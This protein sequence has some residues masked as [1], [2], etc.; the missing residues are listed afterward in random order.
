MM[1]F[2]FRKVDMEKSKVS[3]DESG[4][5]RRN[6]VENSSQRVDNLLL[7]VG[8][9]PLVRFNRITENLKTTI[10][11]KPEFMNPGGSVKDRMVVYILASALTG[12]KIGPNTAIIEAT[13]GNTGVAVAMFGAVHNR[14]VILT[15]PDKMSDE[16]INTL[17]AYGAEVHICPAAVPA[18]SPESYYNVAL[19]RAKEVGDYFMLNQY[20][21]LE[22]PE[23]H[24][25]TTG[26]EIWRQV[27]G[28]IDIL[29]GGVGTGGT[30]SG[31]SRYLKEQNP[32][33]ISVA[34]DPI[35]SVF[36]D[37]GTTGKLIEPHPYFVEGIGEDKPC[38]TMQYE[39][40][41]HFIKVS[42]KE[43]FLA[44]RELTVKEG[45]LVGGSSGSAVHGALK[46]AREHDKDQVMVV[47]LPDSGVKYLSRIYNDD[48]MR[49]HDFLD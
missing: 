31:T 46:F 20:E 17:R 43:S 45:I 32:E 5:R 10:Y 14:R 2:G 41:D 47:I 19:T 13:S 8:N 6:I 36:A 44:A 18:D 4:M 30:M 16:K 21:N 1:Y 12:G 38:P 34:I 24:Y 15:I 29:V 35:G 22:N 49:E 25:L 7:A 37:H 3:A 33:L 26:P 40:I 42:D 27:E 9:T 23:A 48:W 11:A 28:R 39:Y